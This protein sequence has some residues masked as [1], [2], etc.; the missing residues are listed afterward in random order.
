[1]P[2]DALSITLQE[3]SANVEWQMKVATVSSILLG[4]SVFLT[5]GILTLIVDRH[6][7]TFAEDWEFE[8]SRRVRLRLGST[9]YRMTEPLIDELC[10]CRI[11]TWFNRSKI[12]LSLSRGGAPLPWTPDEFVS[13]TLM[14]TLLVVIVSTFLGSAALPGSQCLLIGIALGIIY[15][16]STLKSLHQK[17][18]DRVDMIQ[19][20]MPFGIDLVALLMRAGA[21]FRDA[22]RTVVSEGGDH[23]F[24]VEF[25]RVLDDVNRGKTLRESLTELSER[26]QCEDIREMV[27]AIQKSEELGT[28]LAEIFANLADQ[29]RLRKSQ[30]A[31]AAAG[32]A[33]IK[34]QGPQF[35]IM[36]ACMIT[37]IV[38]F[39]FDPGMSG[40]SD[41]F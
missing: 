13:M 1:M 18:T 17:A 5:M 34:M 39:L 38:P 40:L 6:V 12:G 35:V 22:V 21:G 3:L 20:R 19:R 23:P 32:K 25:R 9:V 4:C 11:M 24:S 10:E 15:L 7:R 30:W 29:M 8:Q 14:E 26:L 2:I 31:E 27:Y 37:I 16:R 33:Q 36:V 41:L 28:P